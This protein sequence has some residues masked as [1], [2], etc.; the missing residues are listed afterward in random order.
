MKQVAR[1]VISLPSRVKKYCNNSLERYI[2]WAIC[3]LIGQHSGA[4][5]R[6]GMSQREAKGCVQHVDGETAC[7]TVTCKPVK[8]R[9]EQH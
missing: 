9:G 2:A 1:I 7:M 3:T 8:G 5:F 6:L 4:E